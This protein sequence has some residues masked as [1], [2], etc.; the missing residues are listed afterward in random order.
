MCPA[1]WAGA[2][3]YAVTI[4]EAGPMAGGMM[5]F[6]IPKYRLPRDILDAE[7]ARILAMG[8]TLELG[9]RVKDIE[10]AFAEGFDAIF[11]ALGA[12]LAKRTA[13]PAHAARRILDAVSLLQQVEPGFAPQLG[14]RVIICGGGNTAMEV[15]RTARRLGADGAQI[16][17]RRTREQMPGH[18][19]EVRE[20]EDEGVP[21]HW[22]RTI[23][24]IDATTC[25]VKKM[26]LDDEGKPHPTGEFETL[27]ADTLVLAPGQDVDTGFL[28]QVPGVQIARDGVI[29]VNAQMMTGRPG[30]HP[31]RS[32]C[33]NPQ[34]A[35]Q[36]AATPPRQSRPSAVGRCGLTLPQLRQRHH[37]LPD[38]LLHRCRGCHRPLWRPCRTLA[39]LG[40]LHQRRVQPCARRVGPPLGQVALPAVD[41][42]QAVVLGHPVRRLRLRR[43]RALHRLVP[44]RRR[45]HRLGP[46]ADRRPARNNL[47]LRLRPRNHDA[48]CRA[49]P[50]GRKPSPGPHLDLD[51]ALDIAQFLKATK[52]A[53]D[54]PYD[55][56]LVEG[57][58]TTAHD[59]A[60]IREIRAQTK[61]P[62]TIGACATAAGI[63]S[64]RNF[65]NVAD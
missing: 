36:R 64:L 13:I 33:A 46:R 48:L 17:Y 6:G 15:T 16:V 61:T 56:S 44:G 62:I 51:G 32:R 57:S 52:V 65:A 26:T 7:I 3:A 29:S 59:A 54:G 4:R 39:H 31:S 35:R 8:V 37:G 43:L 53:S 1:L 20:A 24:Q 21:V 45:H 18:G 42:P 14:R 38:L 63:Q 47:R 2:R 22:L 40:Q 23:T 19:F 30:R 28:G 55:L 27:Q 5:R 25:T 10:A 60:R 41:D 49:K 11:T 34:D 58:V 12:H 9:T 50:D